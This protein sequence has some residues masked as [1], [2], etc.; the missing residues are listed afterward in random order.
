MELYPWYS[1]YYPII[2]IKLKKKNKLKYRLIKNKAGVGF[3]PYNLQ[4]MSLLC[5]PVHQPA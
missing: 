5:F 2:L 4:I 3:E 1:I